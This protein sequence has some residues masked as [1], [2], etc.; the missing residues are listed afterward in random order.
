MLD[1]Y[2]R[3]IR[4]FEV[5]L[6]KEWLS[7]GHRFQLVNDLSY[8]LWIEQHNL[9]WLFS[10]QLWFVLSLFSFSESVMAIRITQTQTAHLFLFN[11]STACGSWLVRWAIHAAEMWKKSEWHD[12]SRMIMKLFLS[13]KFPAAFEF[14]EYFLVTILDHLYSCLFGTFLCNSEQQRMKEVR[15]FH[16]SEHCDS[17]LTVAKWEIWEIG[18]LTAW[19][20]FCRRFPRGR[21]RCGLISTASWRSLPI[22]SMSTTPTM[23]CSL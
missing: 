6:E 2:Y 11:S 15:A 16:F 23:C 7:F 9:W 21:C 4:G 10:F 5:L 3:T 20:W 19:S 14:N 1:G 18:F 13:L 22:L 17:V 12:L 8:S